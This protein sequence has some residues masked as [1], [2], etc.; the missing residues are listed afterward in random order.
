[1]E[2]TAA[3][4]HAPDRAY[5]IERVT[6]APPRADELLVRIVAV[7]MCHTDSLLRAPG[8]LRTPPII[9]GH[10]GAGIVE[11]AGDD[12]EGIAIGDHV[13]MTFEHCGACRACTDARPYHC[14]GMNARNLSGRRADGSTAATAA[15]GAA[16]SSRWFG[17]SS[18]A[19][20][21]I[22]TARNAIVVDRDVPLELAAPLGCGLMTGAGA[23]LSSLDVQPGASVAVF[24]AGAVGLAAVM[25]ARVAGAA[26][27]IAIDL[28]DARL[29]L[30]REL[31]ATHAV[32]GAAGDLVRELRGLTG[33]GADAV[34]EATG[35]PA[36]AATAL[37]ATRQGGRYAQAGILSDDLRLPPL[38]VMGRTVIGVQEGDVDPHEFI[39]RLIALWRD[40]EFPFDRLIAH[41]GLDQIN[42]AEQAA[43]SGRV[44][45]PVL[46]P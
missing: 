22:A 32:D 37:A 15:D 24:G 20:H 8:V 35:V 31:G 6:L 23:V 13:V 29:Q 19:T 7:G 12:V 38:A 36:V 44:I 45:K 9:A 40:G 10:E 11:A 30:A 43:H 5:A 41:F 4:L 18:F 17:Q 33:G 25:A 1:M 21:A 34:V 16:I 26:M 46:R 2:V 28:H 39:P 3:V 14:D 42:E 27:I